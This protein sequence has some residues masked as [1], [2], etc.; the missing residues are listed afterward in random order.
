MANVRVV[1][2]DSLQTV[3]DALEDARQQALEAEG[4]P[5]PAGMA[6]LGP[7]D[8]ETAYA[9]RDAVSH[10]GSAYIA[11]A[12][13]E[14]GEEPGVSEK[15]A[16]LLEAT[17]LSAL[18]LRIEAGRLEFRTDPEGAWQDA[19][20]IEVEP[21]A[22]GDTLPPHREAWPETPIA[23]QVDGETI[24]LQEI[25]LETS[26]YRIDAAHNFKLTADATD[27]TGSITSLVYVRYKQSGVTIDWS[28]I[29]TG[30]ID[31]DSLDNTPGTFA[32]LAV[33]WTPGD[34]EGSDNPG[35]LLLLGANSGFTFN[36]GVIEF[37]FTNG[38]A[39]IYD[40]SLAAVRPNAYPLTYRGFVHGKHLYQFFKADADA[41]SYIPIDLDTGTVGAAVNTGIVAGGNDTVAYDGDKCFYVSFTSGN[42]FVRVAKGTIVNGSILFGAV[43][44][45]SL[46]ANYTVRDFHYG[47][48][49]ALRNA[50]LFVVT[51]VNWDDSGT[52][53]R[54]AV[55][56]GI[57]KTNLTMLSGYPKTIG[58]FSTDG[59]NGRGCT[60]SP[61]DNDTRLII[62]WRD[63]IN[64]RTS[65]Q[66]FDVS[67]E[68]LGSVEDPQTGITNHEITLV[69]LPDGEAAL[70]RSGVIR[71]R[72]ENG[73]WS[74]LSAPDL[75][76]DTYLSVY[77]GVLRAWAIVGAELRYQEYDPVAAEWGLPQTVYNAVDSLGDMNA[78]W[79]YGA[80][81]HTVAH[82][83]VRDGTGRLFAAATGV[84]QQ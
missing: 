73:A 82:V 67:A 60:L 8:I 77:Q 81:G 20:A 62:A 44:N 55:L 48:A 66:T 18:E 11:T 56:L 31:T 38:G 70:S 83:I 71:R 17:D 54:A 25:G 22:A 49:F 24:V 74:N 36:L 13:T 19:G 69:P 64:A 35:K 34:G 47:S 42:T 43:T 65:A 57:D 1:K 16:L 5:G 27:K 30:Q 59:G 9:E 10:Q 14:A 7:W 63:A 39:I 80:P 33:Q 2:Y 23:T 28:D 50:P 29:D 79:S 41:V 37:D 84:R 32:V 12:A 78:W 51:Q 4:P 45:I 76:G 40:G 58:A 75:S 15:W 21:F 72:A 6:W 46:P 26:I 61:F 68:T 52:N 3:L 53:R